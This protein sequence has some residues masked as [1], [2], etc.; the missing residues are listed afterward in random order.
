[1]VQWRRKTA[2]KKRGGGGAM[3]KEERKHKRRRATT[4][5][6]KPLESS[7]VE[8]EHTPSSGVCWMRRL[9]LLN[10]N[11]MKVREIIQLH[12]RQ[13]KHDND[14][15]YNNNNSYDLI[16]KV[17]YYKW[18]DKRESASYVTVQEVSQW[19]KRWANQVA[20][21]FW[22]RPNRCGS[23]PQEKSRKNDRLC[24]EDMPTA[25]LGSHHP[26]HVP[27]NYCFLLVCFHSFPCCVHRHNDNNKTLR[28]KLFSN[29]L[30]QL[31]MTRT[32]CCCLSEHAL[33]VHLTNENGLTMKI[34]RAFGDGEKQLRTEKLT[35]ETFPRK[36]RSDRNEYQRKEAHKKWLHLI[37]IDSSLQYFVLFISC[38]VS[39]TLSNVLSLWP[40]TFLQNKL[41]ILRIQR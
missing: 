20:R 9:M 40:N 19:Y 13:W 3:D 36:R 41:N 5:V 28:V 6:R 32:F 22:T 21:L 35:T 25:I 24:T 12:T 34:W 27:Q 14:N 38:I 30:D 17:P 2:R 8:R 4:D 33:V 15:Y 18:K 31:V 29:W 7:V 11:G 1:M 10:T 37:V 26:S 16:L 39:E 23:A